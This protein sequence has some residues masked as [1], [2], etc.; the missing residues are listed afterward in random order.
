MMSVHR[1]TTVLILLLAAATLRAASPSLSGVSP[2]G[3]QRGT[4]VD[5]VLSGARLADAREVLFYAPGFE[6]RELTATN[7]KQVKVRVHIAED[8]R[9]GEHALRLRTATGVSELRTFWVGPLPTVAEK[10]PNSDFG[11]PQ[12]VEL[13]VTVDGVVANEDVDW[14]A[15]EAKK[16]QRVSA[17]I[18]GMR[19][20]TTIFDPY[21]A[22]L[23]AA[24]FE[25]AA[26]DDSALL[27]QDAT[28]QAVI[29]EDGTYLVQVREAS[30]GGSGAC[31]YRL[32]VGTFPRP[33]ALL[34]AGGRPGT[35]VDVTFIGDAAGDVKKKVTL[36]AATTPGFGLF[37]SDDAGIAPSGNAFRLNDLAD[38]IEAEPNDDRK[39]ATAGSA[40][41]AFSG[42]I[43]TA[44]D[45]DW[46]RFSAKK[47]Q[48]F[49]VELWGRRL[50]SPLD[51]VVDL[52]HAGG[53]RIAANDDSR[54]PDSYFRFT[55]PETKDY[56]VRVRD[57]LGKGGP[58]YAYRLEV[59]PVAPGL[60]LGLPTVRQFSQER[61]AI[62]VPKGNRY[63][64]LVSASRRNFGGDLALGVEGLPAGVRAVSEIMPANV[65]V[66]PV[67]FEAAPDAAVAGSLSRLVG[68]HTDEKTGIR[69]G[70]AQNVVLLRGNP[71]NAIYWS[72]SVDRLAVAVTEEAPFRL[73][74]V[75]PR[76]P[77]VR[78]GSMALRVVA[79]RKKGFDAQIE[80]E[81]VFTP[82]GVSAARGVKIPKGGT[83]ATIALNANG[84]AQL[85]EWKIV[86]N[87]KAA[88]GGGPLWVA[89]QLA[90]LRVAAPYLT[91]EVQKS[92]VEQGKET[93][94]YCKVHQATPFDGNAKISLHGLPHKVTAAPLA[95]S[96]ETTEL[97][98]EV[99]VDKQ[100]PAGRH[101]NVFCRVEIVE[102]GESIVHSTGGTELRIDKPL[103]PPKPKK[104]APKPAKVAKAPPKPAPKKPPAKKQ[105]TRLE[106]LRLQFEQ[107]RAQE[108]GAK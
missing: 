63:A 48:A 66:V 22:L 14:Y 102:N 43:S 61:Q 42:A 107:Q 9:L 84:S 57:H 80:L 76:V 49:D 105:L 103:P 99:Q 77:L 15:F 25:L 86:V 67:V 60:S 72:H 94:L 56:E 21:V 47:G 3:A 78:N 55:A 45:V 11:S 104:A 19:L 6:T 58:A 73:R 17:E 108:E 85:R 33:K 74:I 54:G 93:E 46:F 70:F 82:P 75:E 100:S 16:G 89:T 52:F 5:L 39:K 62:A 34:P 65:T 40:P 20:G 29:P 95:A 7:D 2:R 96:K 71:G 91:L 24:R 27:R 97:T 81:M 18:E 88:V 26:S 12:R 30:Y 31:R 41:G 92:S 38:A 36:P 23:N 10:E 106:K 8:C 87:G 51:P 28:C 79:E 32:H 44:G 83:E 59:T 53:G 90:P 35:E 101:R 64:A 98:F 50:R 1:S 13:N 69:G 4:D 37:A 68:R